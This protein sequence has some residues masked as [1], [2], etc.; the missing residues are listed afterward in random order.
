MMTFGLMP[1]GVLPVGAVAE[2]FG[3]DLA[4]LVSALGLALVTLLIALFFPVVRRIDK[5]RGRPPVDDPGQTGWLTD[6]RRG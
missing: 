1:L 2:W 4:L 3:I 6:E 5:G